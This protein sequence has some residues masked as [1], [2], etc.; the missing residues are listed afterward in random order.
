MAL[1][2]MSW[3][4]KEVLAVCSLQNVLMKSGN[5]FAFL[6]RNGEAWGEETKVLSMV[7]ILSHLDS[8]FI[9]F[10]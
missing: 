4:G 9:T 10:T 8:S 7:S 5:A 6:R 2:D 3:E 1:I